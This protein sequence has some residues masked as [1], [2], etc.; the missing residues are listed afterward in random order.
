[1]VYAFSASAGLHVGAICTPRSDAYCICF[2]ARGEGVSFDNV[3]LTSLFDVPC[4]HQSTICCVQMSTG[5]PK[6]GLSQVGVSAKRIFIEGL[7][8]SEKK[9]ED[10]LNS[11]SVE[12]LARLRYSG[13]ESDLSWVRHSAY[14]SV[15]SAMVPLVYPL[16]TRKRNK[17]SASFFSPSPPPRKQGTYF[18]MQCALKSF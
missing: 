18:T 13:C 10:A 9:G 17:C 7:G 1:M 8:V 4:N 14:A 6:K 12:A 5:R 11:A 2:R 3:L 16:A 15:G